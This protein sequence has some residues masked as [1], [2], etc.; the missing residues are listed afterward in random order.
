MGGFDAGPSERPKGCFRSEATESSSETFWA[1][2][3]KRTPT[4][5]EPGIRWSHDQTWEIWAERIR[6]NQACDASVV[7]VESQCKLGAAPAGTIGDWKTKPWSAFAYVLVTSKE[8]GGKAQGWRTHGR[9]PD[10]RFPLPKPS[11]HSARATVAAAAAVAVVTSLFPTSSPPRHPSFLGCSR[12]AFLA[13][14][15]TDPPGQRPKWTATVQHCKRKSPTL[16]LSEG[17]EFPDPDRVA[18]AFCLGGRMWTDTWT[19]YPLLDP[20]GK[21]WPARSGSGFR[22]RDARSKK[23]RVVTG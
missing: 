18:G 4:L 17:I 1:A 23:T 21:R 16:G 10:H 20:E 8:R 2:L 14:H 22:G 12:G 6:T 11:G 15:P 13:S 7:G 3:D 19:G 5:R 9:P